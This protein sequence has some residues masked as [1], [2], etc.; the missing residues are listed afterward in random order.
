MAKTPKRIDFQQ[1]DLFSA[2][3]ELASNQRRTLDPGSDA[4]TFNIDTSIRELVTQTLKATPKSRYQIAAHM[5]ELT[6]CEITKFQLDTWSAES[7]ETHRFPLQYLPAF[8]TACDSKS[9]LRFLCEKCGGMYIEGKES[10]HMELGRLDFAKQQAGKKE[11]AI[12]GLLETM[13]K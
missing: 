9:L 6:G 5:S 2:V 11:R 13:G 8:V 4:G 10:L 12:R 3:A 7:K 1:L